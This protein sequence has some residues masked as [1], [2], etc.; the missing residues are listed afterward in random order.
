MCLF[1]AF[2]E[3]RKGGGLPTFGMEKEFRT[4]ILVGSSDHI[5]DFVA[6]HKFRG[7]TTTQMHFECCSTHSLGVACCFFLKNIWCSS[8]GRSADLFTHS[9]VGRL[10]QVLV[11]WSRPHITHGAQD[12]ETFF[13]CFRRMP[14]CKA[15]AL[16][17]LTVRL[18]PPSSP[19]VWFCW[20]PPAAIIFELCFWF[21]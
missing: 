19:L 9:F 15:G 4:S 20:R 21:A 14:L 16:W 17:S 10:T 6:L 13:R 8:H 11:V 18:K 3:R 12:V 5:V 2:L 1:K 7:M